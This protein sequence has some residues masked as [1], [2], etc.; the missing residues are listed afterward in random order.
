MVDE[1]LE[2][3]FFS[4]YGGILFVIIGGIA[5]YSAIV[6]E[7]KKYHA[8]TWPFVTDLLVGL[9]FL[10]MGILDIIYNF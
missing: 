9:V 6:M 1:L 10:V 3:F 8:R 2:K 4:I 7:N 5:I